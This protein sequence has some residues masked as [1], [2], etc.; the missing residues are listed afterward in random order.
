MVQILPPKN[1]NDPA[2]PKTVLLYQH[3]AAQPKIM[4]TVAN[5]T[6]FWIHR[7]GS[8]P[9]GRY[10]LQPPGFFSGGTPPKWQIQNQFR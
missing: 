4:T 10:K 5:S 7:S 8:N 9:T 6:L 1:N 2:T 3:A